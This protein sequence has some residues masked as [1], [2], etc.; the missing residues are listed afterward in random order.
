[1]YKSGFA[2]T[3]EAY[4]KAV[5]VV[6]DSL[7]K[8]E[9]L[10]EGKDYLVGGT[11]TEADIRLY[12]TIVRFDPVYVGHFKCNFRTIRAGYPNI[13]SYVSLLSTCVA[14]TLIFFRWLRKLYWNFPAFHGTTNFDHIKTHYYWSHT[15]VRSQYTLLNE[16]AT[17]GLPIDKPTP[18]RTSWS[19]PKHRTAQLMMRF[20]GVGICIKRNKFVKQS[21]LVANEKYYPVVRMTSVITVW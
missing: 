6:F 5:R 2:T 16:C 8:V 10:L 9:K 15:S 17:N 14:S 19:N 7:D 13:H 1:M 12:V 11:L 3:A 4:E 20:C 21:V 18:H